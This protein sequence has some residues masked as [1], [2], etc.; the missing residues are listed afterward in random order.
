MKAVREAGLMDVSGVR[1]VLLIKSS[2]PNRNLT[3]AAAH[4]QFV[5]D[6]FLSAHGVPQLHKTNLCELLPV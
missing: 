5:K 3:I 6:T 1:H 2:L 4:S